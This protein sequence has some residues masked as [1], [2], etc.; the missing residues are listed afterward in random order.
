[1]NNTQSNPHMNTKKSIV[2]GALVSISYLATSGAA[3][4]AIDLGTSEAGIASAPNV[5]FTGTFD[6]STGFIDASVPVA[7]GSNTLNISLGGGAN[8][9][10]SNVGGWGNAGENAGPG[11]IGALSESYLFAGGG[12]ISGTDATFNISG[13]NATDTVKVEFIGGPA[14]VGILNFN[15]SADVTIGATPNPTAFTQIGADATGSTSYSGNLI[16]TGGETN[17]SAARITITSIPEP[18][19]TL[20]LGMAGF[21]LIFIRRRK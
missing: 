15:G 5:L 18:T 21:G 19:G 7:N 1:M 4:T 17:F 13:V 2:L 10:F 14:R 8:I 9:E 6:G 16:G 3:V 11:T 20:L 12:V